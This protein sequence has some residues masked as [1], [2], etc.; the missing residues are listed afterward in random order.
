MKYQSNVDNSESLQENPSATMKST[1]MI[2]PTPSRVE[3]IGKRI[4]LETIEVEDQY[5]EA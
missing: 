4:F 5:P 2:I 3:T 1:T